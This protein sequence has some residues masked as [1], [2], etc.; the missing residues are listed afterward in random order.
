MEITSLYDATNQGL[1]IIRDF[2]PQATENKNFSYRTDDKHPSARLYSPREGRA[3]WVVKDFGENGDV[4]IFSPID[5][6]MREKNIPQSDF[7]LAVQM[8]AEQYGVVDQFDNS[9]NRPRI[10]TRHVF[11]GEHDGD[12]PFQLKD[13]IS[14]SEARVW[15]RNVKPEHLADLGWS[16]VEWIGTVKD[17]KVT[18][19]YST[20]SYPIF[21]QQNPYIDNQGNEHQFYKVYQPFCSDASWRFYSIGH[22]PQDYIFGLDALKR[23]YNLNNQ[24]P[25]DKIL[26]TSGGSDGVNCRAMGVQPVWLNSETASLTP[27]MYKL[28]K[29]YART[30][31]LCFDADD[32]GIST[33]KQMALQYPDIRV[34]WLPRDILGSLHD[35]RGKARKDLKDY[36]QIR[37]SL[38]DFNLLF[39]KALAAKFWI[40][41]EKVSKDGNIT[42]SY[43]ISPTGLCYFLG[44]HGYATLADDQ[45]DRPHYIKVDGRMVE[46][47]LPKN[48]RNFL[49]Q[50]CADNALPVGVQ[51]QVRRSK[52]L[53][54]KETSNLRE[55][56]LNFASGTAQKQIIYFRNCWVEVSAQGIVSH[57]LKEQNS[58]NTYVWRNKVLAHDY[59]EHKAMFVTE[60]HEDGT[61]GVKMT[62]DACSDALTYLRNTSRL[63]WRQTDEQNTP[64]T[65]EQQSEE[66]QCLAA[67]LACI[68]YY[69]HNYRDPSFALAAILQDSF[70]AEDE[71][72]ANGRSGK[73]VFME[74]LMKL[75]NAFFIEARN[76]DIV[77][78]KFL[79]D[80]VTEGTDLIVVDECA[81]NLAF[82]H[83][84]GKI[85]GPFRYEEKGGHPI[86]I[87]ADKA[88]KMIFATNYVIRNLDSSTEARLWP[89][90]FS[91]Y[92][93]QMAHNNDYKENRSVRDDF[94]YKLFDSDYPEERWQADIAFAM[95]CLQ[96]YL[97]LPAE[98]R[99]IMPP[100]ANI[101]RRT[102]LASIG[103][104]FEEWASDYYQPNGG[105]LDVTEDYD[106]V[107]ADYRKET[108]DNSI[109]PKTFTQKVKEFCN[110]AEHIHCYNPAQYTE[111]KED[112][113]RIRERMEGNANKKV[114]KI[115]VRS[116]QWLEE[117][118]SIVQPMQQPDLFTID[119]D[120]DRPF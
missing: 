91:D 95:Q 10:E 102:Q 115:H 27:E 24:Q 110:Y 38:H 73:S 34:I 56:N 41:T 22:K 69:L 8:L 109:S 29:K 52:D 39:Q 97:S 93:H 113:G 16:A 26:L 108:A 88:P 101:E 18:V 81:R 76:P 86:V 80:G 4:S 12:H 32:T 90:V 53:P 15:G 100:M 11:A 77:K 23:A 99:K 9:K 89:Q 103:K 62:E 61:I 70:L 78:D 33:A 14:E 72:Q 58:L 28:L 31:Y 44:L 57:Q 49:N 104:R 96:F 37:P 42:K 68:G 13:S 63:H 83:F 21:I 50:W 45:H 118:L 105:H 67:K 59:I 114:A 30:I 19:R 106:C 87:P 35:R 116:K 55:L 7:H 117:N 74:F 111:N 71:R 65:P 85:T 48:I 51:N 107:I 82:S 43:G 75:T 120:D 20:D 84:F 6:F 46:N 54:N 64:L 1:D 17:G 2:V 94:G 5:I 119:E 79:Y 25:L 36:L 47:V 112:G 60:E 3:Y 92:Y 66:E 98:R 40:E